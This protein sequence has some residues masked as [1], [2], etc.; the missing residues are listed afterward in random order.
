MAEVFMNEKVLHTLEYTKIISLLTQKASSEPGR[1]MC[2]ELKP[3]TDLRAVQLA[4][5]E[6][7][8]ALSML[9]ARGSTSFGGNRDVSMSLRSLEIG[10]TLSAPEL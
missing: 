3:M 4:Q 7:A 10:S 9:F 2:R 5:Q 1:A 8:D 6:T